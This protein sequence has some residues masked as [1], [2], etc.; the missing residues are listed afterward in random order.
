M[1]WAENVARMG[2]IRNAC[3]FRAGAPEGKSLVRR[4]TFAWKDAVKT[5]INLG[6]VEC[7][8]LAQGR[9]KCRAVVNTIMNLWFA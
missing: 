2:A 9:K 1:R 5:H 7:I 3:E 4:T 8:E 6:M